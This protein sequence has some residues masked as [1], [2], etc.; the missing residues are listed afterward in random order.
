MRA[1]VKTS[2]S[3]YAE[4]IDSMF[5]C[6]LNGVSGL[7]LMPVTGDK[8]FIEMPKHT[9]ESYIR[10]IYIEGKVDLQ[11]HVAKLVNDDDVLYED[12]VEYNA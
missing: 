5:H 1:L 11:L 10:M 3:I 9:A 12:Y 4:K 8:Y 7:M 2:A 6:K